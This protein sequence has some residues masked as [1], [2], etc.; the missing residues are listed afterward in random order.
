[1]DLKKTELPVSSEPLKNA[2]DIAL[3]S[4]ENFCPVKDSPHHTGQ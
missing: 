1:M 2:D 4:S 3:P